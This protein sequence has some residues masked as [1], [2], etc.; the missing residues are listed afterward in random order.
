MVRCA[1]Q[2]EHPAIFVLKNIQKKYK[3]LFVVYVSL[4]NRTLVL[5]YM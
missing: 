2:M 1:A 3:F 4:Q 5:F